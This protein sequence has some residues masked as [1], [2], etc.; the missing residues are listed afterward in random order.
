MGAGTCRL[1]L[2]PRGARAVPTGAQGLGNGDRDV[3]RVLLAQHIENRA[4]QR[5]QELILC[6]GS[7]VPQALHRDLWY[8]G[9]TQT[10]VHPLPPAHSGF[11]DKPPN[12]SDW[13]LGS[14]LPRT[15]SSL[16]HTCILHSD[17]VSCLPRP[18]S[19][20][21]TP[22]LPSVDTPHRCANGQVMGLLFF[23]QEFLKDEPDLVYL[24]PQPLIQSR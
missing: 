13:G 8:L 20:L 12:S 3:S 14:P 9:D 24:D 15:P 11:T 22:A 10:Q 1:G 16:R 2:R 4:L 18:P 23:N 17:L 5:I 21:R 6:P 7:L 19:L